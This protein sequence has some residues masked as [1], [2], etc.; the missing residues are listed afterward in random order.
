M[1]CLLSESLAAISSVEP[2]DDDA[3]AAFATTFLSTKLERDV[4]VHSMRNWCLASLGLP[5]RGSHGYL[6]SLEC[7]SP[8]FFLG[9]HFSFSFLKN[10]ERD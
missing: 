5:E 9:V 7:N 2:N 6:Q 3:F 8:L 1:L 4:Q 10:I